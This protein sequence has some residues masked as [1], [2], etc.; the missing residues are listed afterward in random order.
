MFKV[1]WTKVGDFGFM[2]SDDFC[3]IVYDVS[4][5]TICY[6]TCNGIKNVLLCDFDSIFDTLHFTVSS[7][8]FQEEI[9]CEDSCEDGC[10]GEWYKFE[11]TLNGKEVHYEGRTRGFKWHHVNLVWL[12]MSCAK[13]TLE[14][15]SKLLKHLCTNNEKESIIEKRQRLERLCKEH[16]LTKWTA[17]RTIS[18]NVPITFVRCSCCG[19]VIHNKYYK[20]RKHSDERFWIEDDELGLYEVE[21]DTGEC[22]VC[23]ELNTELPEDIGLCYHWERLEDNDSI[24]V[25]EDES[26]G[27][28]NPFDALKFWCKKFLHK[29]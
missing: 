17:I 26:K 5:H 23:G 8:E 7:E 3:K 12:I 10:D 27:I 19:S 9:P 11:Y 4:N 28:K 1:T 18:I 21:Y 2:T 24:C 13:S 16:L 29:D 20:H 15:E 25:D 22:P 6:E 14:D